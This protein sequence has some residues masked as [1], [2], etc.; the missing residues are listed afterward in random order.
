MVNYEFTRKALPFL[1]A[2]EDRRFM[3]IEQRKDWMLEELFK[4]NKEEYLA[5][6]RLFNDPTVWA[7]PF[8]RTSIYMNGIP[9]TYK[10]P[11]RGT[12]NYFAGNDS[13]LQAVPEAHY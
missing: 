10:G 11:W 6:K 1:Q 13:Y 3:A 12:L 5:L 7:E 9:K 8:S 4:G 2:I